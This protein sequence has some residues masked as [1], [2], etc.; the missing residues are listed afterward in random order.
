[1]HLS[2]RTTERLWPLVA[3]VIVAAVTAFASCTPNSG[4]TVAESDVVLTLFDDKFDFGAATTYRLPDTVIHLTSSGEDDPSIGRDNDEEILA[5]VE[6]N[7]TARGYTKVADTAPSDFV[8][9]VSVTSTQFWNIVGGCW[10]GCW[11]WWGGWPP[12]GWNP[13]FPPVAGYSFTTGSLLVDMVDPDD[14]DGD[15]MPLRW[16][17]AANGVLSDTAAN[18]QNRYA[19]SINQMFEQSPYLKS[20]AGGN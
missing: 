20:N 18:L 5:L 13:W 3:I 10:Y 19:R 8:V 14:L 16:E 9:T 15:K 11:G 12:G 17:G 4:V 7:F 6:S 1:M 2:S